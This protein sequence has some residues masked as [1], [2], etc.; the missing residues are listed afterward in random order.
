MDY[1][2]LLQV[3]LSLSEDE[4][5]SMCSLRITHTWLLR[6]RSTAGWFVR[7]WIVGWMWKACGAQPL[8]KFSWPQINTG[9][10]FLSVQ[11]GRCCCCLLIISCCFILPTRRCSSASVTQQSNITHSPLWL[12]KVWQRVVCRLYL[13]HLQHR[14]H[15]E[16]KSTLL[17]IVHVYASC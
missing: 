14:H 2:I 10:M 1:F 11:T 15:M 17:V 3:F 16:N 13:L 5:N 9:V 12:F 8:L 4:F 6:T 7:G